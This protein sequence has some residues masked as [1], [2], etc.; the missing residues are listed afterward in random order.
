MEQV[1]KQFEELY[2]EQADAVYRFCL[3]KTSSK[4]AAEDL[5]QEAFVRLWNSMS[6]HKT[7]DNLKAFLYQITR[8]LVIDYYRKKKAVSLDNLNEQG[9]EPGNTDHQDI[10]NKSE[11]NIVTQVI[12]QL[13]EKHRDV[14]YL[15][16][17]EDMEIQEIAKTL[18][19]TTNNATVRFHRGMKYLKLL[20]EHNT[21]EHRPRTVE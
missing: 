8:N 18:K 6:E 3:Y 20:V 13:D 12:Q 7:I 17:I 1:K 14:I 16:L 9:F 5:V 15:K 19:I 21:N 10:E 4:E 11:I 2:D